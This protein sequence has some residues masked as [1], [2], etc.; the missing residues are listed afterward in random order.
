MKLEDK[1]RAYPTIEGDYCCKKCGNKWF[2]KKTDLDYECTTCG[3]VE[4]PLQ[5]VKK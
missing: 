5:E 1:M 3:N 4:C 2:F